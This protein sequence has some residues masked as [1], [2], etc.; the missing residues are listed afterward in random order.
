[1]IH[2]EREDD[3]VFKN[4]KSNKICMHD[5]MMKWPSNMLQNLPFFYRNFYFILYLLYPPPH[6]IALRGKKS[7]MK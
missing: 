2:K 5:C 6:L 3:L 1:M 4:R 7:N